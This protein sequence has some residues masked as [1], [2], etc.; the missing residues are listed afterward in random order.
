MVYNNPARIFTVALEKSYNTIRLIIWYNNS[1]KI[2]VWE[3]RQSKN[4][5]LEQLA[6]LTGIS[7]TTLNEIENH[8][9][10]PKM[11]Q[12][13][14]IARALDMDFEDLYESDCKQ[15]CQQKVTYKYIPKK[16][17]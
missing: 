8:N 3:A 9:R 10:D 11:G 5:T 2:M 17:H 14:A 6:K 1:M 12:M 4:V 16:S 15:R 13:E 7:S